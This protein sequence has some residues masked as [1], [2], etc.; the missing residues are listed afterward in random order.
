M[1][2][3]Q[4]VLHHQLQLLHS[5]GPFTTAETGKTFL[6]DRVEA[7]LGASNPTI[8]PDTRVSV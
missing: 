5:F 1:L 7:A 3:I 2:C 6:I 4:E 8:V